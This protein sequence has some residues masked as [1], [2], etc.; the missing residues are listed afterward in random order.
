MMSQARRRKRTSTFSSP[1]V[2]AL[3]LL[4]LISV[5]TIGGIYMYQASQTSGTSSRPPTPAKAPDSTAKSATT[6]PT[7]TSKGDIKQQSL[8]VLDAYYLLFPGDT[9]V[10]RQ[11]R[12]NAVID[13]K[14]MTFPDTTVGQNSCW[15]QNRIL[16][17][18]TE[19]IRVA[20]DAISVEALDEDGAPMQYVTIP[21]AV[22]QHNKDGSDFKGSADCPGT[23]TFVSVPGEGPVGR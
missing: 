7:Q 3:A 8:K 12:I 9:A 10:Q 21:G 20:P 22:V 11:K 13:T 2:V 23:R 19:R 1:D 17:N 18:L 15:D 6:Q 4:V 14:K 5:V 16:Y